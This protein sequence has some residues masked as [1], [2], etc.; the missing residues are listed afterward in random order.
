MTSELTGVMQLAIPAKDIER[1]TAFYRDKLGLKLLMNGPNMA[2]FDCAGVRL[3]LDANPGTLEAGKNSMIYFRTGNIEK[4][5]AAF[6]SRA[7][8]IHQPPQV[9]ASLPDR[10]VW[11]MWIRDSESNLLGVMEERRK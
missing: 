3:Y 7:V 6:I 9:I 11:L 5:H 4:A 1:A 8:P 10:D 2:F